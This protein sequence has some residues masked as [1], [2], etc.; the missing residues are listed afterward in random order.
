MLDTYENATAAFCSLFGA[1][2]Y[3]LADLIAFCGTRARIGHILHRE[4]N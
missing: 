4:F 2:R 1:Q 3:L